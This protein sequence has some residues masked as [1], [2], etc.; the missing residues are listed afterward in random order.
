MI[1]VLLEVA[2]ALYDD[3]DFSNVRKD[4]YQLPARLISRFVC[5]VTYFIW[6]KKCVNLIS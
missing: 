5:M 1:E 4:E 6:K 3:L 2:Q